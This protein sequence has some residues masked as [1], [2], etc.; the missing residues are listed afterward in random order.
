MRKERTN[1]LTKKG[2]TEWSLE[3]GRNRARDTAK[4]EKER[5]KMFNAQ[6]KYEK[7]S[8]ERMNKWS[9]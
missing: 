1:A 3:G 5:W 8:E 4:G 2:K 6:K 9:H 7:Q